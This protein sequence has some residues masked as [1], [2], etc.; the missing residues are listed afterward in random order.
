[1]FTH[2]KIKLSEIQKDIN[3]ELVVDSKIS[4]A[5]KIGTCNPYLMNTLVYAISERFLELG[6]KS[7]KNV[8]LFV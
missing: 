2:K 5:S 7:E 4:F 6:L 3:F 1:M 8:V